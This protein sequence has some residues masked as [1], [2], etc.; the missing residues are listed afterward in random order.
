VLC[1]WAAGCLAPI[2][3]TP[4]LEALISLG[5]VVRVVQGPERSRQGL[6]AGKL[7]HGSVLSLRDVF[8]HQTVSHIS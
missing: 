8:T 6:V 2:E 1:E 4:E 5:D 3:A 7:A